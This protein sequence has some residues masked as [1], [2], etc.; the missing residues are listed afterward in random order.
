VRA[1]VPGVGLEAHGAEKLDAVGLR[2]RVEGDVPLVARVLLDGVAAFGADVAGTDLAPHEL[3]LQELQR[4]DRHGCN[5]RKMAPIHRA[6]SLLV[7]WMPSASVRWSDRE[8][9]YARPSTLAR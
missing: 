6:N 5:T 7:G 3:G 1:D 8:S 4:K 2:D 9:K